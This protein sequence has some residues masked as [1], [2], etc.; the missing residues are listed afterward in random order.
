MKTKAK[1]HSLMRALGLID[2][3]PAPLPLGLRRAI[4]EEEFRHRQAGAVAL[5]DRKKETTRIAIRA[6][7]AGCTGLVYDDGLFY[8]DETLDWRRYGMPEGWQAYEIAPFERFERMQKE[9][10]V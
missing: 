9:A 5:V 6:Q 4:P 2:D 3:A 8:A 1:K 10:E 7:R